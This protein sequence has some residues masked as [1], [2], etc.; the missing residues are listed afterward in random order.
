M[1][2]REL[3]SHRTRTWDHHRAVWDL[4]RA[5]GGPAINLPAYGVVD[6]RRS[7]EDN[8]GADHG[9]AAH[10]RPFVNAAVA[11]DDDVVFDDDRQAADRLEHS[12]D[13]RRRRKMHALS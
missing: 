4:E 5:V 10:D 1:L 7:S 11:A 13:L 8:A 6:R 3:A 12:A 9:S 2:A